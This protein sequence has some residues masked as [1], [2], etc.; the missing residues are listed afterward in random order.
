MENTEK[1]KEITENQ[2]KIKK[3][4]K[5]KI[6]LIYSKKNELEKLL[7]EPINVN[8]IIEG[9]LINKDILDYY[10][11]LFSTG[12][13]KSNYARIEKENIIISVLLEPELLTI[14]KFKFPYNF[15]IVKKELLDLIVVDKNKVN[16]FKPYNILIGKEGIFIWNKEDKQNDYYLIYYLIDNNSEINKIYLYKNLY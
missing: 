12:K 16:S 10:S 7:A 8:N 14:N 11:N 5:R 13:I 2:K 3:D 15:Y 9:Y 6:G 1:Q 4:Y